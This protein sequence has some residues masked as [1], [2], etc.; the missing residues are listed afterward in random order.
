MIKKV[1]IGQKAKVVIKWNVHQSNY[2]KELE[3]SIIS[4]MSKKYEI[5]EKNI[6]IEVNYTSNKDG[7]ILTSSDTNNIHDPKFQLD[8]MRQYIQVNDIKDVDFEEIIKIDSQI[9]SLINYDVYD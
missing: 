8:L 1:D 6:K 9:N 7:C 3:R 5:P 2:S 4:L